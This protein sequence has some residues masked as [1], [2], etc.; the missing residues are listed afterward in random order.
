MSVP[1]AF[2]ILRG[3]ID[4]TPAARAGETFYILY[5]RGGLSPSRLLLS[6]LGLLIAGRLDGTASVLDISDLLSR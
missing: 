6:P 5:D 2:P 3:E 1:D 4:A